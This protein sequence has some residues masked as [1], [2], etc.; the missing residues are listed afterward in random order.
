MDLQPRT[1]STRPVEQRPRERVE[2]IHDRIFLEPSL[3]VLPFLLLVDGIAYF[4]RVEVPFLQRN[5][6][7]DSSQLRVAKEFPE[8]VTDFN[9]FGNGVTL[10]P[11]ERFQCQ[12]DGMGEKVVARVR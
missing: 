7:T 4:D 2:I 1:L 8:V 3:P 5:D 9:E 10:R 12:F 11:Q 6:F